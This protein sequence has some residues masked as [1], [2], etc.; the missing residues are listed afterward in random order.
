MAF[1]YSDN[2]YSY[3]LEHV[4][5]DAWNSNALLSDEQ[6]QQISFQG[7]P[8]SSNAYSTPQNSLAYQIPRSIPYDASSLMQLPV[9]NP[10]IWY[11]FIPS[12]TA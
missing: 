10:E 11:T 9:W 2:P 4:P 1:A 5:Q 6:Q 3:A 12:N 7:T 8:T